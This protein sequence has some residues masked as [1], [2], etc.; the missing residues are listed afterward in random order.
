MDK[1]DI[2]IR[3]DLCIPPE[4]EGVVMQ[5]K[6]LL[7]PFLKEA[8]IINEHKSNEERGYIDVE[9]CGHRLGISCEKVERWEVGKGK[10][11]DKPL[12]ELR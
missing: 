9:R 12:M 7:E 10:M 1:R 8:I 4:K 5:L 6:T 11:L 3:I 2:R